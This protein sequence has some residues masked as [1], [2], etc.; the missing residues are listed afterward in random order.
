MQ[1]LIHLLAMLALLAGL[2]ACSKATQ[3]NYDKIEN[4][5]PRSQVHEIL[6]KPDE[7]NSSSL[8]SLSFTNDSWQGRDHTISIQYANDKVKLKHISAQEEQEQ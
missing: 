3:E 7:V 6:G 2:T 1:K 8:G 5:M 4:D